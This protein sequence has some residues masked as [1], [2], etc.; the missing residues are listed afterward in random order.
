MEVQ[1]QMQKTDF[2]LL[3]IKWG[4]V[5]WEIRIEICLLLYIEQMADN[6]LYITGNS[7][8]YSVSGYMGKDSK[9]VYI[10]VSV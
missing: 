4:R 1:S 9:Q 2:W 8:Q 5:T 7:F 3:G 10:Y 6:L